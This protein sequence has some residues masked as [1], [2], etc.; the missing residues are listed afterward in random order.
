MKAQY[1]LNMLCDKEASNNFE[2]EIKTHAANHI[3]SQWDDAFFSALSTTAT[4][5]A[6]ATRL[7]DQPGW[8]TE[9]VQAD[10]FESVANYDR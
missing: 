4:S 1:L 7:V 6:T 5:S 8:W 10:Y 9:A 2:D 3:V